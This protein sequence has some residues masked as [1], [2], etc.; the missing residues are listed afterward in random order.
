MKLC[1][2]LLLLVI[3]EMTD[4]YCRTSR[5]TAHRALCVQKKASIGCINHSYS[6]EV[7]FLLPQLNESRGNQKEQSGGISSMFQMFQCMSAATLLA[8]VSIYA[9]SAS[10]SYAADSATSV[11]DSSSSSTTTASNTLDTVSAYDND[12]MEEMKSMRFKPSKV[13]SS[14]ERQRR[15]TSSIALKNIDNALRKAERMEKN[16]QSAVLTSSD[17]DKATKGSSGINESLLTPEER[18]ARYIDLCRK[19]MLV[20]KAYL[21]EAEQNVFSRNYDNLQCVVLLPPRNC[22]A[23]LP[24][25][26]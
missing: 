11:S 24:S 10:P 23:S 17:K 9:F 8:L 4:S 15:T 1:V 2:G 14:A 5:L 25:F 26:Q 20:L 7:R 22:Y 21:D 18:K 12:L 6:R 3:I 13:P 19:K 16:I